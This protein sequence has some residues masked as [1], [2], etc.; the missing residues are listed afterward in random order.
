LSIGKAFFITVEGID[1]SGKSTQIEKMREYFEQ[2]GNQVYVTREPGGTTIS[3]RIREIL[4]D[5]ESAEME[6]LTELFLFLAS[7]TQHTFEVIKPKL[8]R[9]IMVISD[10]YADS[11]IAF[12]GE[13]RSL[14]KGLVDYLNKIATGG[15]TP[16]LT[17]LLDIEPEVAMRRVKE[18]KGV[19]PFPQLDRMEQEQLEF[20]NKVRKAYLEWAKKNPLRIRLVSSRGSPQE[21]WDK[22]KKELDR[23]VYTNIKESG[24][25]GN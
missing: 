24:K 10:R 18:K 2:K 6:P 15:L 1:G 21:T 25:I 20:H 16:D 13:G 19:I 11:S 7:R 22:I 23:L 12:Q 8:K 17:I 9:G 14:E 3:E 4:L 5:T